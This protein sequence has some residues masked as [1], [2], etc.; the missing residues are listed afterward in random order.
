MANQ[1]F[2]FESDYAQRLR[3]EG[4]ALG[5]AHGRASMLLAMLNARHAQ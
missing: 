4:R 1:T 3:A 2:K 5:E